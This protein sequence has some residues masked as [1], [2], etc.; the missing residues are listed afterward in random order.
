MKPST[1]LRADETSLKRSPAPLRRDSPMVVMRSL[2]GVLLMVLIFAVNS[3]TQMCADD[4]TSMVRATRAAPHP[5]YLVE[6]LFTLWLTS[7]YE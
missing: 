1:S 6:E 4:E 5:L 7:G 2:R 3:R